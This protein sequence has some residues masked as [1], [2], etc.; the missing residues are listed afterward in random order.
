VR[1]YVRDNLNKHQH[2]R[3]P[4]DQAHFAK[5]ATT[6]LKI[7]FYVICFYGYI[8]EGKTAI[9]FLISS[10]PFFE[11]VYFF[12]YDKT[13]VEFIN[14]RTEILTILSELEK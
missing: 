2:A 6:G 11:I 7:Y 1:L 9:Y 13:F 14:E 5:K 3:S 8:R 12:S 10:T 4:E